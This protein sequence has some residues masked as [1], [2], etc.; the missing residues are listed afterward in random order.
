VNSGG[1]ASDTRAQTLFVPDD[2]SWV[3]KWGALADLF[4]RE[5]NA[6]GS[7]RAGYCQKRYAEGL[8]FLQN[9]SSVLAVQVDSIPL[10]VDGVTNGDNFNSEWE[11][12]PQGAP[13]SCYT[14][15]LNLVGFPP[16]DAG[17][18]GALLSTVQNAPVPTN[19]GDFIQAP[20]NVYD[21]IID[22]AQHLAML[23]LGGAEFMAT[24]PLYEKF[25]DSAA[26]YNRKLKQ[27]GQFQW[28]L[29]DTSQ[30]DSERNPIMSEE[31]K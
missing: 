22:M 2:W 3:V 17:P 29:Y 27:Q 10:F 24:I 26:L 8:Q 23:K 25:L 5:S 18:Y 31:Q 9:A 20:R 15:G 11:A 12:T 4:S 21:V 1:V 28:A 19:P 14:T 13:G 7:L 30:T 16:P 6:K